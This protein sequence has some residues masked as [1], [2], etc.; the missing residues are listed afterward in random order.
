MNPV[1]YNASMAVGLAACSAGAGL[2][3]GGPVGCMVFGAMV[4]CLTLVTVK[5]Y[6]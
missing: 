4:I 5:A 6:A 1:T 2:Q 3:W